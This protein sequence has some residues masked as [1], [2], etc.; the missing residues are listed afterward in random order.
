MSSVDPDTPLAARLRAEWGG[1]FVPFDEFMARCLYDPEDGF[2]AASESRTGRSGHF[3]TSS[4]VGPVFGR[5]LARCIATAWRQM[6]TPMPFTLVEQGA[7][8]G[9]LLADILRALPEFDPE[10]PAH[11]RVFV[12]EPLEHATARQ[13]AVLRDL[14]THVSWVKDI[15]DLPRFEGIFFSNELVDSFPVRRVRFE[16]GEWHELR[17]A[18]PTDSSPFRWAPV[19][20]DAELQACITR[21]NPPRIEGYTTEFCPVADRWLRGIAD[22]LTRGW[23]FTVDYFL[24]ADRYYAPERTDGTLRAYHQHRMIPDVLARPGEQDLTTHAN[25]TQLDDT[26][27]ACSLSEGVVVDQ[28]HFVVHLAAPDLQAIERDP[29]AFPNA[30]SFVREFT[31][32]MHPEMMGAQFRVLSQSRGVGPVPPGIPG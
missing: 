5:L 9:R 18:I 26:G 19:P 20:I 13:F 25:L 14:H 30:Q 10:C 2:Y 27:Q 12:V 21:W 4:S 3:F 23:I 1:R 8:D 28:H 15:A 11:L 7:N 6:E 16:Q 31:T 29:I 17:V 32:L 22:R 24:E